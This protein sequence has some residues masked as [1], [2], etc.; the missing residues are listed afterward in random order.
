V[1]GCYEGTNLPGGDCRIPQNTFQDTGRRPIFEPLN[2]GQEARNANNLTATIDM[3]FGCIYN[4]P[5][6]QMFSFANIDVSTTSTKQCN[7][8][9]ENRSSMKSQK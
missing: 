7:V 9:L 2:S 5:P 4:A 8:T 1:E 6:V 3:S